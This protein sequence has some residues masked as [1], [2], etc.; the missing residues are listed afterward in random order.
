MSSKIK[1]ILG[2][3]ANLQ[4]IKD[5]GSSASRNATFVKQGM[6]NAQRRLQNMFSFNISG[7]FSNLFFS[8]LM[9]YILYFFIKKALHRM[10]HNNVVTFIECCIDYWFY[11][12]LFFIIFSS[13]LEL[14]K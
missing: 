6:G 11:I 7:P 4:S 13:I 2:P 8:C 14:T 1:K 3:A 9:I 12:M 10:Q 5:I